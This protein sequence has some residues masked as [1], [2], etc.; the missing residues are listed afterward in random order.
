MGLPL[1]AE[2]I[3]QGIEDDDESVI[4]FYRTACRFR[5]KSLYLK[6]KA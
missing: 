6:G 4:D 1:D 3:A 2:T 5:K